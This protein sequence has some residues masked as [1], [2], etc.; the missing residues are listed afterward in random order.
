MGIPLTPSFE[1]ALSLAVAMQLA[2]LGDC[3]AHFTDEEVEAQI[4][5]MNCLKLLDWAWSLAF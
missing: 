3:H 5:G 2:P 4:K 1:Q